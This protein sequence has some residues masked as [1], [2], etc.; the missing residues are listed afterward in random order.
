MELDFRSI[1]ALSSRS[2]IHILQE[3]LREGAT[4]SQLSDKVGANTSNIVMHLETLS[5]AGL[6]E[7]QEMDQGFGTVYVP[8]DKAR[9]IVDNGESQ[10]KFSVG[11]SMMAGLAGLAL[12]VTR[13]V[14]VFQA[15]TQASE[16]RELNG[17]EPAAGAD[18][19]TG[20]GEANNTS[21]GNESAA[22][23]P[24]TGGSTEG[25]LSMIDGLL[26]DPLTLLAVTL[27]VIAFVL[28]VYGLFRY[29]ILPEK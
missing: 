12:G 16:R 3:L 23:G 27:V 21:L 4:P 11:S 18:A 6:V 1:K 10:V 2:R 5:N 7:E 29:R 20:V 22:G 14:P 28:L 25:A 17:G 15:G 13:F 19:G 9:T 26:E 8:T 24:E